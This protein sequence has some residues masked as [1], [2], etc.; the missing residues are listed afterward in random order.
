MEK[1]QTKTGWPERLAPWGFFALKILVSIY[2]LNAY[3][4]RYLRLT[5]VADGP[6]RGILAYSLAFGKPE[7]FPTHQWQPFHLWIWAGLLKLYPDIY[8]TGTALNVA[9]GAGTALFMYLLGRQLAGPVAGS[10]AALAF[11]FSPVH[12]NL[13]LAEG[14]SESL[15]FFWVAAGIYAASRG[16]TG[17]RGA[18]AAGFCLA[19]A[20]LTRY[21]G[22]ML[23]I[24]YSA[25]RLLRL[26]PRDVAG[27]LLWGAPLALAGVLLGHR[28]LLGAGRGFWPALSG[29]RADMGR[30]LTNLHWYRRTYYGLERLWI[31]GRLL[32]ALGVLGAVMVWGRRIRNESRL[33]IWAAAFILFAAL[34]VIFVIVGVGF[35]PERHFSIVLMLLFPFAGLAAVEVWRRAGGRLAKVAAALALTA[36]AA[37]TAYFDRAIK[38]Y[39]YGHPGPCYSCQS[40][41]AELALKLRELWRRGEL[42]PNEIIYMEE[43]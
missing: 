1:L 11:I 9:A 22:T 38:D 39:G 8:W 31:D 7:L 20:A 41:D 16:A 21:E 4:P 5:Y 19:A 25:Y 37:Y 13:T 18:A 12:H 30:V 33:L 15:F 24:L 43:N 3:I 28:A 26:R 32:A 27:W 10:V 23:L 34:S 36:V 2:A 42:G 29:V 35:C 14:T 6:A 40:V 17:R